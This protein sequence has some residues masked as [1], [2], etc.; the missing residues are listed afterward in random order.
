MNGLDKPWINVFGESGTKY[1]Y[2]PQYYSYPKDLNILK[3]M[4]GRIT[5]SFKIKSSDI[6]WKNIPYIIPIIEH[7]C[8][9]VDKEGKNPVLSMHWDDVISYGTSLKEFLIYDIFQDNLR[10]DGIDYIKVDFWLE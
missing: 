2:H 7:R 3:G 6:D 1:T 10:R 8:L 9:I 5:D 4:I